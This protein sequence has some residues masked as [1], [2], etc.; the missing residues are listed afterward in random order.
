MT[1]T[2]DEPLLQWRKIF[3]DKSAKGM[4]W[5]S[6]TGRAGSSSTEVNGSVNPQKI[7]QS[8]QLH[9]TEGEIVCNRIAEK[10]CHIAQSKK[11]KYSHLL[12]SQKHVM[13][14]EENMDPVVYK[15]DNDR[16]R[17]EV[18]ALWLQQFTPVDEY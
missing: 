12:S 17:K 11:M 4:P 10:K 5:R 8:Y 3:G 14:P 18:A 2:K 16:C 1:N 6:G 9:R 15:S 13:P 7:K